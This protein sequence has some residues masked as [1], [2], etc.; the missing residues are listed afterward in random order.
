MV[1]QFGNAASIVQSNVRVDNTAPSVVSSTPA[2]GAVTA[3]ASSLALTA[4]EDLAS[5][6]QLKLDGVAAGFVPSLT[7]PSASFA[8]GALADGNHSL[9][10]WLHDAAGNLAPFRLN[11]TIENGASTE[12]P[13]TTKN[14]SSS[15]PTTLS[16]VDGATTVTT[17]ANVWQAAPPQAQDFLVLRIDPSP[18]PASIPPTT[19]QLG[20]SIVDVRMTWDLAGTEEHHFDAPVQIDL[21]DSTNGT[22]TPVTAEP[23]GAWRAIPQ[24]SA[25]GTLPG[26]WQDGYWRTGNVVHILTR[27]LSLFAIL[28]GVV[29]DANAAPRDF[30]AV[31]ADDGLTLRWAPGIPQV[32]NFVLYADGIAI[33]QFG[34]EQFET[35]LGQ[36]TADDPRRFT[37]TELNPLGIESAHTPVLRAVPPLAGLSQAAAAQ[38]LAGRGFTVGR[39][40]QV[41]APGIP[42]GTV[43]GPTG[44][45]VQEEGTSVDIQ[46][47]S[48]TARSPFALRIAIAPTAHRSSRSLAA[49]VSITDRARVD[50]TLD[51][52]PFRRMQRWHFFH[53]KAGATILTLKLLHTLP[54]GTYD[55]HWKATSD[56]TKVVQRKITTIRVVA[57]TRSRSQNV[58]SISGGRTTQGLTKGLKHVSR[59]TP[60]QAFLYASYHDVRVIVVDADLYGPA[61]ARDLHQVF[62]SAT[63]VALSKNGGRR[64]ALTSKGIVAVP[65][66]T[67]PA[68]VAALVARLLRGLNL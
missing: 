38:A 43:V 40:V 1:D 56:A 25:P 57:T 67:P 29:S 51:G 4:S 41:A 64:A 39:V 68:Q 7:G 44:V 3:S 42:A 65:A 63:V 49:R 8:T 17:P 60:D 54:A 16:S 45:H 5:I 34:G 9:T 37:L 58:V 11:I 66:S 55:L 59:L 52:K 26:A 32:R 20:S 6:T 61:L 27:H 31:I 28:T 24:L 13:D 2:D 33:A 12:Q 35:K 48:A 47:A 62:P 18:A 23:G 22:G 19:I 53:V 14:V 21:N 46:V 15:F 36:I 30:A 50:V 10:G